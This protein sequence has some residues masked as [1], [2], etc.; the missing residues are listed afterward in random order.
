MHARPDAQQR[1]PPV[2]AL[3]ELVAQR[4]GCT[5]SPARR[6]RGAARPPR[7]SGAGR[8][9]G[10]PRSRP[11]RARGTP[12]PRRPANAAPR[13]RAGAGAGCGSAGARAGRSRR[14]RRGGRA[15]SR[16]AP[17]RGSRTAAV[18]RAGITSSVTRSTPRS[19]SQSR[20]SAQRWKLAGWMSWIATARAVPRHGAPANRSRSSS[21]QLARTRRSQRCAA[22]KRAR[23]VRVGHARRARGRSRA[24]GRPDR[25]RAKVCTS[26]P[27]A[28]TRARSAHATALAPLATAS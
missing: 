20:I 13:A 24:A 3:R 4:A 21:L 25:A 15:A 6:T 2:V 10:R 28:R 14:P 11:R 9:P 7:P 17:A 27:S 12:P 1:R 19:P 26:G 23:G 16:P 18:P 8:C 22:A 5:R